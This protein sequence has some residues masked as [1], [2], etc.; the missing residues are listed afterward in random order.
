MREKARGFLETLL[1]FYEKNRDGSK[2][3]SCIEF[4]KNFVGESFRSES[5]IY[6]LPLV[7]SQ[8]IEVSFQN[9]GFLRDYCNAHIKVGH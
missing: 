7:S 5:A 3:L 1:K 2:K 4:T 9:R 6:N 8:G